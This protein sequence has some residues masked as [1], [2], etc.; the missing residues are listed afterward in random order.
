MTGKW[1]YDV[2]KTAGVAGGRVY[3]VI[4]PQNA[5]YPF[6]TY[7]IISDEPSDTKS[8]VSKVDAQRIQFDSYSKTSLLEAESIEQLVRDTID[9]KPKIAAGVEIDGVRYESKTTFYD[10]EAE[11]YRVSADYKIRLKQV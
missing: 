5:V 7:S 11:C 9:K 6:L 2:L 4:A 1:I 3:P 10:N 8:G